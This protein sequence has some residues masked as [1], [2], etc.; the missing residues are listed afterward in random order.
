MHMQP[1]NMI[2][3]LLVLKGEK[4]QTQSELYKKRNS[5]KYSTPSDVMIMLVQKKSHQCT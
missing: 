3:Y 1:T 2:D 4:E 5:D